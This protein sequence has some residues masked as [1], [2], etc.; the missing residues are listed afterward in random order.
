MFWSAC[1][2]FLHIWY[3]VSALLI[4]PPGYLSDPCIFNLNL[5]SE[6]QLSPAR[7]H[8]SRQWPQIQNRK[9]RVCFLGPL[10]RNLVLW[11]IG[12]AHCREYDI[13]VLA[14]AAMCNRLLRWWSQEV[15]QL[16]NV[17]KSYFRWMQTW[18]RARLAWFWT[19]KCSKYTAENKT[20]MAISINPITKFVLLMRKDL[21]QNPFL[22][23][24][25]L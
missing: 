19:L 23:L 9:V 11:F 14:I 20:E 13:R 1:S 24:K 7:S 3:G 17:R 22:N 16:Q 5:G 18:R 4:S 6:V 21:G 25:S 8:C 15:L 12:A 2:R 10:S